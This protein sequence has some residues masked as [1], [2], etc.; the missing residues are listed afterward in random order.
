MANIEKYKNASSQELNTLAE[1]KDKN[2]ILELT[3]RYLL[4]EGDVK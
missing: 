2:A 3:T 4:G 1:G